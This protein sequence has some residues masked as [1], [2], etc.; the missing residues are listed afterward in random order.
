M[1]PTYLEYLSVHITA[2]HH[3]YLLTL[4]TNCVQTRYDTVS[5]RLFNRQHHVYSQRLNDIYNM[6]DSNT[7]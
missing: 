5:V 2:K 4:F 3:D 6:Y 1:C 7:R